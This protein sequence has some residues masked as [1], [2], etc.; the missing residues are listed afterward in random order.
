M[1]TAFTVFYIL[2]GLQGLIFVIDEFYFHRSRDLPRWERIGHPLDTFFFVLPL[3]SLRWGLQPGAVYWALV[4][5]SC[6]FIT[7]DEFV[8]AEKAN[9]KELWMH[10]L[11]F[12][13]HPLVLYFATL[14][15]L[16]QTPAYLILL[17]LISTLLLYQVIYWNFIRRPVHD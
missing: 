5:F 14:P 4:I 9:G 7:K 16:A 3:A 8:H 12:M 17:I 6:L 2:S 11:L 1:E 10:S 15:G 13:I